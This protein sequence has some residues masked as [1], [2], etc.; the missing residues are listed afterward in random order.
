[1]SGLLAWA[2]AQVLKVFTKYAV[3]RKWDPR[4]LVGSGGMPSS[5][6]ALCTGLTAAVALTHGVHDALFPVCLG[7][8]LIVMY[9]A[10]GVRRHAGMHAQVLNIVVTELLTGHPVSKNQLK[11]LIGH[12]P[13]QV[14]AGALLGVLVAA[15]LAYLGHRAA[16]AGSLAL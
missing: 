3:E 14:A 8:S 13:L 15:A 9:D 10:A 2:V 5:H 1:M 11:E 6:A 4:M 12:T 16:L 7:F